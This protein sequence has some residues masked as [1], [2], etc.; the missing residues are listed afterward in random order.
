MHTPP[1]LATRFARHTRVLRSAT[2]LTDEQMRQVAPSIFAQGKHISRS[3]KYTYI[4]TSEVLH[5]LQAEGFQPFMVAQGTTRIEGKAE[6]TKHLIRLRHAD[7]LPT[8]LEVNEIILINSHDGA[9]SY[10][11]LAGMFRA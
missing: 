5:S 3:D 8:R 1:T 2:P 11:M 7:Q 9:S 6:F 4:P 10:Q